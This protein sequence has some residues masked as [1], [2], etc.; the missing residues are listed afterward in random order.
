MSVNI[1]RMNLHDT[2]MEMQLKMYS[3]GHWKSQRSIIFNVELLFS[4]QSNHITPPL[5]HCTAVYPENMI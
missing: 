1:D 3:Y 4:L 2:W 5:L